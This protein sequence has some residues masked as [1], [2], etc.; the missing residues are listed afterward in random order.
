VIHLLPS[1]EAGISENEEKYV[2]VLDTKED[3]R[4][5]KAC[6]TMSGKFCLSAGPLF[7]FR[8]AVIARSIQ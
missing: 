7:Y 1:R 3:M 8:N 6:A 2:T 4:R 5:I